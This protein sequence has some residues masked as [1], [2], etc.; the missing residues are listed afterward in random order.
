[1][2]TRGLSTEVQM[3]A[4][5]RN[6]FMRCWPSVTPVLPP[7]GAAG[8]GSLKPIPGR[9]PFTTMILP[10]ENAGA[11]ITPRASAAA[12]SAVLKEVRMLFLLQRGRLRR[13]GLLRLRQLAFR[14]QLRV[15]G[16]LHG[17]FAGVAVHFV[18]AIGGRSGHHHAHEAAIEIHLAAAAQRH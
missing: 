6:T 2:S 16:V 12:A 14:D 1:M 5:C 9:L 11:Q 4:A 17:A 8:V 15:P 10:C 3:S 7:M 13:G 18:T